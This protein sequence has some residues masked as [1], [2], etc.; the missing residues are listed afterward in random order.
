[1]EFDVLDLADQFGTVLKIYQKQ[2][3]SAVNLIET[4]TCYTLMAVKKKGTCGLSYSRHSRAQRSWVETELVPK[5]GTFD[6]VEGDV[7]YVPLVT[8]EGDQPV[9]GSPISLFFCQGYRL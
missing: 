7:V 2:G 9:F 6:V 8:L 4:R 5:P 3:V 1:M